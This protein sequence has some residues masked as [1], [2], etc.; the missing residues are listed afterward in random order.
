VDVLAIQPEK[1]SPADVII[2]PEP[3]LP[4]PTRK[5]Y[6]GQIF[7]SLKYVYYRTKIIKWKLGLKE[8]I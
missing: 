4:D 8:R 2:P 5:E 1:N 7:F 6:L 3:A